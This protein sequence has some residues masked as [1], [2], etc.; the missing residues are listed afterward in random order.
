MPPQVLLPG[1]HSTKEVSKALSQALAGK[2]LIGS[3]HSTKE[4]SKGMVDFDAKT[5]PPL[6]PFH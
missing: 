4:V 3:F 5:S 2:C 6:F 1:F